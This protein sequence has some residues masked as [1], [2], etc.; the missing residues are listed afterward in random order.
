MEG[1]FLDVGCGTGTLGC[2]L[3]AWGRKGETIGIDIN[4]KN[5]QMAKKNYDHIILC[6]ARSLPFKN[7]TFSF[8]A[9]VEVIEHFVKSDGASFIKQLEHLTSNLLIITTPNGFQCS[10]KHL[11]GYNG[12]E[13]RSFGFKVR[14]LINRSKL[15]LFIPIFL[16][17][18]LLLFANDLIAI[19]NVK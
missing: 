3:K 13:L 1:S 4:V 7:K 15:N 2:I 10:E 6:D 17:W 5:L 19:K 11:C 8:V 12:H 16:S 9:A 18:Y 14:G